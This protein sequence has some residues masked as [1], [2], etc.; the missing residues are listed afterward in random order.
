[1]GFLRT[2]ADYAVFTLSDG[3]ARSVDE[4]F[5]PDLYH[6]HE[7]D[8]ETTYSCRKDDKDEDDYYDDEDDGDDPNDVLVT[9]FLLGAASR[10]K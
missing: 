8:N 3:E 1:M 5:E 7:P 9:A 6:S 2:L 4:L 10:R